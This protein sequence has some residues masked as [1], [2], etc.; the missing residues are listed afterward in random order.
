MLRCFRHNMLYCPCDTEAL[1]YLNME[2]FMFPLFEA[3]EAKN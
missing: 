1:K 3:D 2:I